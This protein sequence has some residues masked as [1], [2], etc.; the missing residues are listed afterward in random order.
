[1]GDAVHP[2]TPN[3]GQGACQALEDAIFLADAL[4]GGG[5]IPAALRVYEQRRRRRTARVTEQ[6]WSLGKILQWQ[7]PLAVRLRE[8]I[9]RTRFGQR[10]A[11]RTF[12]EM[13][14]HAPPD[15]P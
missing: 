5:D 11:E 15:L 12:E 3:L 9:S 14:V 10:Q 8:F 4:R 1:L 2:T 6:S 13:L 7:N